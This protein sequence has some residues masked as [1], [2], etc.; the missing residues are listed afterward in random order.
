MRG[1]ARR[2]VDE[3]FA[4]IDGTL[5][6]GPTTS[7]PVTAADIRA[8]QFRTSLRGYDCRKVDEALNA[9]VQELEQESHN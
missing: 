1:Y 3:L 4:R 6:R 7:H 2:Q 5:G 9:A 8:T